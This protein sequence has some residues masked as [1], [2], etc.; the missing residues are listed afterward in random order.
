MLGLVAAAP[1]ARADDPDRLRPPGGT[2]GQLR[3]IV[4]ATG[5]TIGE[6]LDTGHDWLYRRVPYLIEDV[7]SW[8]AETGQAPV[9]APVSPLRLGIEGAALHRPDGIALAGVREFS[10]TLEVPNIQRRLK[11]FITSDDLQEAPNDPTLESAPVRAGLRFLAIPHVELEFGVRPKVW[12]SV[13]GAARWASDFTAGRFRLYPFA[14]AYV[15]TGLGP[16]VSGGVAVD[17]WSGRWL[18]RSASYADWVHNTAVTSWSQ[19]FIFGYAKAI[20]QERNY[21]RLAGGH[22]L[23]CGMAVRVTVTGDRI[24]RTTLYEGSVLFKRPLHGGWLFGYAGPM[25]RWQ[26]T[27][28]WHP[29]IGFG[30]GFDALFWGLATR[31]AELKDYCL[32]RNAG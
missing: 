25:V 14:K 24:S 27:L 3:A 5:E 29:D 10:A 7:D 23:A 28:R 18:L 21:D 11:V 17:R 1:C 15:E 19:S 12:P 26:R 30:L 16:G 20:I 9:V 22:D 8:F 6:A 2:V 13:F 31:P 4:S 32:A